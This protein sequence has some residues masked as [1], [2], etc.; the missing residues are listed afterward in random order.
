VVTLDTDTEDQLA[1]T[2]GEAGTVH[3]VAQ[4][5]LRNA[6]RHSGAADVALTLH[7]TG[8]EVVLEVADDGTGFDVAEAFTRPEPGHFGLALLADA[9][10]AADAELLV[11]SA[12]GAGAHWRLELHSPRGALR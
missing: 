7:R 2:E 8:T 3:R 6:A 5:C 9:V 1:L 12:P 11:S 10:S 4:E